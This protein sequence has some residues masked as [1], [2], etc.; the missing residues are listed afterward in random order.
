MLTLD[1]LTVNV[2]AFAP[3]AT[4]TDGGIEKLAVAPLN[5]TVAPPVGAGADN[6][7]VHEA[8]PGVDTTA[9]VQESEAMPGCNEGGGSNVN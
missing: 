2:A 3:A 4:T 5:A 6:P 1:P 9:G 7:T 8:D